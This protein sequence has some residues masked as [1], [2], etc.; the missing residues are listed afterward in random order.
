[1][2]LC[3]DPRLTYLNKLGYNV[4]RLPR[5]GIDPL[6]ILGKDAH[7]YNYLGTLDQIWES[8]APLPL[9]HGPTAVADLN[10]SVTGNIEL[11][12]GL[13][14]LAN[15]LAGMFGASVPNVNFAYRL[16]RSIQFKFVDVQTSAIVPFAI[17]DYLASGQLKEGPFVDRFFHNV[18]ARAFLITEILQANSVAVIAKGDSGEE[19]GVDVPALESLLKGKVKVSTSKSQSAETVYQGAEFLT[20][21]FKAFA[22]EWDNN[23]WSIRGVGPTEA[24]SFQPLEAGA[25]K[26]EP[27][28]ELHPRPVLL[29]DSGLLDL[30]AA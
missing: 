13:D 22:L 7:S 26:L 15:V 3:H 11:S 28:S 24:L 2:L 9:A 27:E 5:K 1:M 18:D 16:A 6:G 21:G 14:I 23:R 10:G 8:P 17:N 19:V 25:G 20:F 12:L 30:E 29:A 4:V